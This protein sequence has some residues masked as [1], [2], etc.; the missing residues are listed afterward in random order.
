MKSEYEKIFPKEKQDLKIS[1]NKDTLPIKNRIE[2]FGATIAGLQELILYGLKGICAYVDHAMILGYEDEEIFDSIQ[3]TLYFLSKES[4]N[5]DELFSYAL[6][7]G[8]IN[9]KVMELLDKAHTET[10]KHPEAVKVRTTPVKGKA[11]V[12]SGH[13]LKDLEE[14]LKQTQNLN[15]NIYTHG[16]MLPAHA[17]PEL[18]KYKHLKGHYGTAWQNQ[19]KEFNEFPG[20]ILM[21]T[22]CIQEPK[23]YSERIFTKGVV[24]YKEVTHIENMD[25]KKLIDCALAC[26]GFEEDAEEK[27]ITTGFGRNEVLKHAEKIIS[28]V[29]AG[30]IRH[31]FLVGGCDGAKLGRNYYTDLAKAIPKDCI[32]LT[33]ACGKFRFNNLEFGDI[34][35]IPR[36]LDLGQCN[37][38]YS[39]VKIVLALAEAF[40][41][42]VN[43]LPLSLILSWY[44]QKAVSILLS[45]LYLDIKNI[46]LGPS[47]PAFIT[48]EVLEV[49]VNKFQIKAITTPEKDLQE[50]LG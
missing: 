24:G 15:I 3:E 30:K 38:A 37:D 47:L 27:Y 25:Y 31:F 43:N 20:A 2:H 32:I 44:E 22:N 10:Y 11:I 21:T 28:A 7:C 9:L 17:Y 8:Q 18:N 26:K 36:L 16:E 35:G 49:L 14:L 6:K 48:T 39:A 29:K 23:G 13:D 33:L 12:V 1:I 42:D 50:I 45:L 19:I 34:D 4:N 40:N 41:T 5:L 46:R